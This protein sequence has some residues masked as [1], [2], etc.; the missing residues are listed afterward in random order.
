MDSDIPEK[1]AHVMSY[2]RATCMRFTRYGNYLAAGTL[3]SEVALWDANTYSLATILG[4]PSTT[5]GQ[6]V[7]S[8]SFPFP[9]TGVTVLATHDDGLVRFW[10]TLPKEV[11]T[12]I[13]FGVSIISAEPHPKHTRLA[14]VVPSD[15][16]PML[17]ELRKGFYK[18][19]KSSTSF[20]RGTRSAN[21]TKACPE[22]AE[23]QRKANPGIPL[24]VLLPEE[25]DTLRCCSLLPSAKKKQNE[26]EVKYFVKWS[27]CGKNLIRASSKGLIDTF[28]L[29]AENV[30]MQH[31]SRC[32]VAANSN[33][34]LSMSMT[35]PGDLVLLSCQDKTLRLVETQVLMDA[36]IVPSSS[37]PPVVKT[38]QAFK[39][40]IGNT[41]WNCCTVSGDG[42]TV[43]ASAGDNEKIWLWNGATASVKCSLEGSLDNVLSMDW[44]PRRNAMV[45]MSPDGRIFVW[46]RN[47][48]E[49]WCAF[50]SDFVELEANEEYSETENEFDSPCA[51]SEDE[52]AAARE[53]EE[54]SLYCDLIGNKDLNGNE[55]KV[56]VPGEESDDEEAPLFYIPAIPVDPNYIVKPARRVGN[57][58]SNSKR[59]RSRTSRV[60]SPDQ[61]SRDV[62]SP[63]QTTETYMNTNGNGA[64]GIRTHHHNDAE[65]GQ[66]LGS[67]HHHR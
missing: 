32:V 16:V 17:V 20:S 64:N 26:K 61:E 63:M 28:E 51:E 50:A 15:D 14:V 4:V 52:K 37:K 54:K 39:D 8:V 3:R 67:Q 38:K 59:K 47:V 65:S 24:P 18:H 53:E 27:H 5:R 23:Q 62:S 29:D 55:M 31:I 48:S 10:D 42:E 66:P 41:S 21:V 57:G 9:R 30:R 6:A 46:L 34:I 35:R 13:D 56:S 60:S 40:V 49:N 19:S 43:T 25:S 22:V 1:I 11:V 2:D 7:T 12:E 58:S 45:T 33:Q 36:G 44:H